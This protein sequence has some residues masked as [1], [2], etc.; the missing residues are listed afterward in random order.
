MICSTRV[1]PQSVALVSLL[2]L[3]DSCR[4]INW[5]KT[6]N[7]WNKAQSFPVQTPQERYEALWKHRRIIV[8]C[9]DSWSCDTDFIWPAAAADSEPT[10]TLLFHLSATWKL[11][12]DGQ[13]SLNLTWALNISQACQKHFKA[14]FSANFLVHI[15]RNYQKKMFF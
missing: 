1:S 10:N 14:S 6:R 4:Q 8:I 15:G 2:S 12:A 7:G 9:G 11:F 5:T 3:S 13:T